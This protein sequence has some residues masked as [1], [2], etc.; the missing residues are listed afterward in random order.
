MVGTGNR[1]AKDVSAVIE[2]TIGWIELD[3]RRKAVSSPTQALIR[4]S[5]SPSQQP[6]TTL[7]QEQ[8]PPTPAPSGTPSEHRSGGTNNGGPFYDSAMPN[9]T[10]PYPNMQ[11][12]DQT[13]GGSN[14]PATN[15]G[16]AITA[17]PYDPTDTSQFM[18]SATPAASAAAASTISPVTD[19]STPAQNPLVAFASQATQHVTAGQAG[20]SEDWRQHPQLI[21]HSTGNTWHEWTAAIADSQDRYSANA[22]LTLGSARP[23]EIAT[24]QGDVMA[25]APSHTG[26][27]PLL[28]FHEGGN[29][30]SGA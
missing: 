1:L 22:L 24:T 8:N 21:S 3:M 15:S 30:V 26:Q 4:Q 29:S 14:T 16:I 11:Y 2:K 25:A 7:K 12:N 5:G 17:P 20:T 9:A 27:W 28:L 18:Y 19:Q 23:N 10:A 6:L 13:P